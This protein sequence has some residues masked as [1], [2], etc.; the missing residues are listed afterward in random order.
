MNAYAERFVRSIKESCLD[1]MIFSGE[2]SLRT[3]IQGFVVPSSI[4]IAS[5]ITK[6]WRTESSAQRLATSE[7][8]A[9]FSGANTWAAC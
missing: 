3:A 4:I 9:R 5:G 8:K 6:D 2:E 7:T 1:R